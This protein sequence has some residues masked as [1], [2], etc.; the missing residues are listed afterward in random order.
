MMDPRELSLPEALFDADTPSG[1]AS[2]LDS[3]LP[4]VA[5]D[6]GNALEV[7][8]GCKRLSRIASSTRSVSV[9]ILNLS[10][11]LERA[12]RT[13]GLLRLALNRNRP[14]HLRESVRFGVWLVENVERAAL[15]GVGREAGIPD[16]EMRQLTLLHGAPPETIGAV[17]SGRIDLRLVT[18]FLLLQ[19]SDRE[20]FMRVFAGLGLSLQTQRELLEWLPEIVSQ[21]NE[22]LSALFALPEINTPLCDARLNAPQK[23]AA[24]RDA[25]FALR[26]HGYQ[27]ARKNWQALADSVNPDPLRVRFHPAQ[28]FERDRLE[29]AVTIDRGSDAARI[30]GALA[31]LDAQTWQSLV[32]PIE[33]CDAQKP[34]YERRDGC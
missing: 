34:Y 7:I 27:S 3:M 4:I 19:P 33:Q 12:A 1:P 11:S 2:A 21:R 10:Q 30:F 26:F 24:V 29:V 31:R 9:A 6:R 14:L 23:I 22:P 5:W 8:D 16:N 25:V 13:A 28:G 15:F 17:A 32:S 20:A 18:D